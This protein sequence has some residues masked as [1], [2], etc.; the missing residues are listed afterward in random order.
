MLDSVSLWLK[1]INIL[2]INLTHL[3]DKEKAAAIASPED[4][5]SFDDWHEKITSPEGIH[6]AGLTEEIKKIEQSPP[7]FNILLI[8]FKGNE[9]LLTF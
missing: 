1:D 3:M 5:L 2:P 9:L 7:R 6:R 8:S 4:I